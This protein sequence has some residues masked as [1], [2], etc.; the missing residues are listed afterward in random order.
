MTPQV[1]IFKLFL[2]TIFFFL[3]SPP[4]GFLFLDRVGPP[5]P[6]FSEET[7]S[8]KILF[9]RWISEGWPTLEG[10]TDGYPQWSLFDNVRTWWEYRHL[11]NILFLH[12]ADM[13]E[14]TEGAI[15]EIA[16]FL[17]IPI[18]EALLP[19]ILQA[20][21]LEGM[22]KNLHCVNAGHAFIGGSNSFVNKGQNGRWKGVL[23]AEQLEKY[24]AKV[25]EKL[26]PEC[27]AWLENGKKGFHPKSV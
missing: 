21:S 8:E 11:P 7:S 13:L 26:T 14:D 9:D 22:K 19:G 16:S 2:K 23:S 24:D 17:E 12:Y 5:F 15:R 20:V 4:P 10:E 6:R 18:Q 1:T 27:A 3:N 25:Q